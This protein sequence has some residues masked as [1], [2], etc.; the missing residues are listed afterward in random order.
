MHPTSGVVFEGY[1]VPSFD[2]VRELVIKASYMVPHF[3]LVSWDV[4]VLENGEPVL[5]EANLYDGQLDLHQI[6][7]G[8]LFGDR[9]QEILGEVFG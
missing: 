9:T 5:I 4:A 8:P 7:N 1:E 6:S 3:R 2:K